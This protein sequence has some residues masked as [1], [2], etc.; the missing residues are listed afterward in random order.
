MRAVLDANVLVSA[1][2]SV[3]GAPARLLERW[4]TG[5]F[6]LV[7]SQTLLVEVERTLASAKIRGRVAAADAAS[8]LALLREL[9]EVVPDA[10]DPPPLRSRDA[11]DDYLL[12]LAAR[13]RVLL[14]TGD[15]D[16]LAL[17]NR[18]PVL[19]PR[20]FLGRLAGDS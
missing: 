9:A 11:E 20:E 3:S 10:D 8:F 19:A 12:A 4:L 16:L 17:A 2:L 13:E 5:D 15:A 7:L 6:D 14:V 18:A 1:L